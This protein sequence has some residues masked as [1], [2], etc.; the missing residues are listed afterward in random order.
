[1]IELPPV[2]LPV[3][4]ESAGVIRLTDFSAISDAEGVLA[5]AALEIDCDRACYYA[6]GQIRAINRPPGDMLHPDGC[7]QCQ[8]GA[9][10]RWD[11]AIK[12]GMFLA[13][14][15]RDGRHL[16]AVPVAS[17]TAFAWLEND[18]G[19]LCVKAGTLGT[20]SFGDAAPAAGRDLPLL[21]WAADADLY[22]ACEA[23]WRRAVEDPAVGRSTRPRTEKHYPE[24]FEYLGWCSW[25]EYKSDIN[26]ALL[27]ETFDKLDASGIPFRFVLVD[28]GHIEHDGDRLLKKL[29]PDPIKFP[30]GWGPLM[31]RR[32]PGRVRW[33]GL[34]LNFNG[35][36]NGIKPNNSLGLDE[37]L[38]PVPAGAPAPRPALQ[39]RDGFLHATA[40]YDAF[41][42]HARRAGFDFVKVDNQARNVTL[43]RGAANA[44]RAAAANA[45]ALEQAC[46]RHMDGLL[47]CMAHNNIC[48]FNTRLSA[49][50][51]CSE[52]YKK[53]DLWRAK[54]HLLDSYA[55]ALWMGQTVWGDHDMF[56]AN[57]PVAGGVMAASKAVSGG[58]VYLSDDPAALRRE[59]IMP[60]CLEDGRLLRPLAPAVPLPE[61]V[62]INPLDEA[63]PYRVIAPLTGR[64][65][66]VVA[67]NLTDPERPVEGSFTIDDYAH[68]GGMLQDGRPSW[69]APAGGL[70]LY[71]RKAG[72]A[73]RLDRA[74][75]DFHIERFGDFFALLCPIVAGW[76]V[77]GREDKYLSPAAVEVLDAGAV[78]LVLRLRETGPLLVWSEG[79]R[80]AA[81]GIGAFAPAGPDG[82][83]RLDLP[84]GVVDK[85]LRI[86][87]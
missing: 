10:V 56:H 3:A 6:P 9:I 39:P 19:R 1:M 54:M 42:G 55:N 29:D 25:E 4:G 21:A 75:F 62:Y 12:G 15:L 18:G 87:R 38:A 51:R 72:R 64:A 23:A 26:E 66:A 69:P 13:A 30:N 79:G 49:V 43:Y 76:A 16:A 24:V 32:E 34:W 65:A 11:R 57:D 59:E 37:H 20:E 7:N 46:A 73:H 45:Q 27:L 67:Y 60:L 22:A 2:Q 83:W 78:E 14:R 47:N 58:P 68:A 17:P 70:L 28:D 8:P 85:I 40:F 48:V 53:E 81:V 61:S 41:I 50:T 44:A 52:D 84:V 86:R 33:I 71:D 36:W 77:I 74:P 63:L 80:L 5:G 35:Y 82:L 31:A